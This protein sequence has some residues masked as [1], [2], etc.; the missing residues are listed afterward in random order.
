[1][2][3]REAMRDDVT[4]RWRPRRICKKCFSVPGTKRFHLIHHGNRGLCVSAALTKCTRVAGAQ[5]SLL[6][7]PPRGRE[8]P[9]G[10]AQYIEGITE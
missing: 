5:R 3:F 2:F 7:D 4:C 6:E 10:M 9:D 1:M 8:F